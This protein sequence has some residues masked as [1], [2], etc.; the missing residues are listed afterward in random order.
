MGSDFVPKKATDL[1]VGR[2]VPAIVAS[3]GERAAIRFLEF[4]AANIRNRN[5]RRAY[6]RAVREF[7]AWCETIWRLQDLAAVQPMHV[8]AYL[9]KRLRE[10]DRPSVKQELAAIRMLFDWLVVGQV[11]PYNPSSPSAA[12]DM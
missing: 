11:L 12:P 3:H 2:R 4:F 8:A 5:T 10:I 7:L 6:S 9:E 1:V